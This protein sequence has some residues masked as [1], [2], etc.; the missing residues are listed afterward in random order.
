MDIPQPYE[1]TSTSHVELTPEIIDRARGALL[2]SACGD[3]LGVPY[4]FEAATGNPEMIGGG[5][6]PYEPGQWSDDTEMAV[7]IARVAAAGI[8]LDK[9]GALDKVGTYFVDWLRNGA[10][11]VGIQTRAVIE[12][13]I[14]A[15]NGDVSDRLTAS[16]AQYAR[17]SGRAGGNGALMRT[18]PIGLAFLHSRG[19]TAKAA[20]E[21]A[22]LTHVDQRVDESCVLWSEAIRHA[23][24]TGEINIRAGF[25]LLDIESAEFWEEVLR[26]AESGEVN[27]HQTGYTVDALACAWNAVYSVLETGD[28]RKGI[29]NAVR[30]GGDTDTVATIAG[31]LIGAGFGASAVPAEWTAQVHGWPGLTATQ[32]AD[33][34]EKIVTV[35]ATKENA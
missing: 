15:G 33:M 22:Q 19:R 30:I 12:G 11:D 25:D 8:A 27:S 23:V 24:V 13:A 29:E 34:G 18:A 32:F 28:L 10:L 14:D 2:A 17:A 21:V 35:S 16:A 3:A 6:G 7:C 20:T 1:N 4:E 5:L 26:K 31:A 9:P